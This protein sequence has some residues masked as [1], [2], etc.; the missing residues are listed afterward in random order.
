MKKINK[1][2]SIALL[3][4][5]VAVF[6]GCSDQFLEDKKLYGSFNGTT[7]YEN[8]ESADMTGSM[9]DMPSTGTSDQYSKCTEEYGGISGLMNPNSPLDYETVTDYFNLDN[10]YSPWVRIRECND[11]IEG[12]IGSESL[13]EHQKQLLLGQ[14]F[15]FRAWRYYLMV[16]MYGGVPII[17]NVQNPIIGDSEGIHLVVP[18]SSTKECIDWL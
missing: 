2:G 5:T 15:F 14:A 10:N 3:T 9:G 17:D 8:Y 1:Y 6:T 16:M 18:R 4:I 7:I 11:M 12:V 13:T